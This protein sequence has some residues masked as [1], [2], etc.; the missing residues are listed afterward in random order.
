EDLDKKSYLVYVIPLIG[1]ICAA[2]ALLGMKNKLFIFIMICLS[3]AV[4]LGG[5][6][7][8]MTMD[9]GTLPV[10]I[11]IGKGLWNTLYAFL[12]IFLTGVTWIFIVKKKNPR[13]HHARG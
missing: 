7:N 1:I 8:I 12:F 6:R 2:L 5:L 11:V 10:S 9:T 13:H 4:S 3:G